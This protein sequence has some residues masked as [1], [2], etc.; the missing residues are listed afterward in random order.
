ME[1]N[2]SPNQSE[3]LLYTS[4]SGEVKVDVLLQD[5]T[6]WLTQ[7]ALCELFGVAK[8]IISEH[9]TNI[10]DS[11]ELEREATVRKTRTVHSTPNISMHIY[12]MLKEK[13]RFVL[14]TENRSPTI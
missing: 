11:G 13:E 3:F 2:L 12:N 7:K 9:F 14:C 10:Y 1:E 6:V 4:Q 5:E 8:S